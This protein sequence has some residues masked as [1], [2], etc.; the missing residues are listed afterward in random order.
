MGNYDMSGAKG[1]APLFYKAAKALLLLNVPGAWRL[2]TILDNSG[3]LRRAFSV[4]YI[5][6]SHLTVPS[7][8]QWFW[9]HRTVAEY[10]PNTLRTFSEAVAQRATGKAVFYDCGA[11]IGLV[12]HYM[13]H[14][15]PQIID[16][17]ICF[18][19]DKEWEEIL[20]VNCLNL[21]VPVD[22][23]HKGVGAFTGKAHLVKPEGLEDGGFLVPDVSGSISII[24]IDDLPLA[25]DHG[26][27]IKIDVEGAELAVLQ[28]AAEHLRKAPYFVVLFEAHE[29]VVK[30]T[31]I[32]PIACIRF[33]NALRPCGWS[34]SAGVAGELNLDEA[35][36]DQ[37]KGRNKRD[38]LVWSTGPA[39]V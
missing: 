3:F 7:D 21:P 24:R 29:D 36:F 14:R 39:T 27:V 25:V 19:P 11:H 6:G 35:F 26:I 4:P 20:D 12:T 30:R 32:D 33:L 38:V 28:G 5:D 8:W 22:V 15:C 34:L 2:M 10:E 17:A 13:I 31:G 23:V 9:Q 1:S 16:Q 37:V 18:E